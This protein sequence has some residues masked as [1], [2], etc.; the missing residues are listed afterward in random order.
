MSH[1]EG[2]PVFDSP[3]LLSLESDVEDREDVEENK[4]CSSGPSVSNNLVFHLNCYH[5]IQM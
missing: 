4:D 1:E 2:R 5:W 3:E